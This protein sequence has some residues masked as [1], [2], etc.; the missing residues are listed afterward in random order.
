MHRV[1]SAISLAAWLAVFPFL[2]AAGTLNDGQSA[3]DRGDYATALRLFR[4][5]AEQGDASAQ[6]H[7]GIMYRQGWGVPRD[8]AEAAKWC[9]RAAEQ[10]YANA[11]YSLAI[12]YRRGEGMPRNFA[13]AVRWYHKAAE[14]GHFPAQFNLGGMYENG[15]GV[16]Q[17]YVQ[18]YKWYSLSAAREEVGS[19][20]RM[21]RDEV[22][23]KMTPAQI[24]EAQKLAREWKP[25]PGTK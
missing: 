15:A 13:E 7:L 3:L 18:A 22:A 8:Y 9:R 5:L 10:G 11:Q 1:I 4:P 21:S 2:A 16:P 19:A 6:H 14:Q 12:M 24:A 23:T 25:T 17:N 20:A